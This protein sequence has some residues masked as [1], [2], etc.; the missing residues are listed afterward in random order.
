MHDT[1]EVLLGVVPGPGMDMNS[2]SWMVSYE[3]STGE[4][5]LGV[6]SS[7]FVLNISFVNEFRT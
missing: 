3:G 4:L 2:M 6:E 7:L 1:L 5:F